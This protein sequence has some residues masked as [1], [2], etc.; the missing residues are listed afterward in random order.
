MSPAR[1]R[2]ERTARKRRHKQAIARKENSA[3][4]RRYAYGTHIISSGDSFDLSK[5][6][7]VTPPDVLLR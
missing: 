3:R 1:K 7:D 4:V 5:I 2:R 6:K